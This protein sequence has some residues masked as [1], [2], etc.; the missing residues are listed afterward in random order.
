MRAP[1]RLHFINPVRIIAYIH[2]APGNFLSIRGDW[3]DGD[4]WKKPVRMTLVAPGHWEARILAVQTAEFKVLLD[5]V[6]W[7][8]GANR[9]AVPGS[10]VFVH[11][12]QFSSPK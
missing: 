11:N 2:A 7:E 1:E 10:S 12:L 9:V 3:P 8:S 5:D 4:N 6:L